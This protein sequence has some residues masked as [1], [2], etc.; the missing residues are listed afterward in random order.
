MQQSVV[1]V[2][3]AKHVLC[4]FGAVETTFALCRTLY[5]LTAMQN[6]QNTQDSRATAVQVGGTILAVL[7]PLCQTIVE[8]VVHAGLVEPATGAIAYLSSGDK[9]TRTRMLH[10]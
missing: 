10:D 3:S 5:A 8:H 9:Q 6:Q 2:N 4:E 7:P 1:F